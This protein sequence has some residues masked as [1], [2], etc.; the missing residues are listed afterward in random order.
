MLII[1]SDDDDVTQ[2]CFCLLLCVVM[3]V[4]FLHVAIGK[5]VTI[6]TSI[7]KFVIAL[8]QFAQE[9]GQKCQCKLDEDAA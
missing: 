2:Q 8:F 5:A 9:C 7:T 6:T 4:T 3:T 1:Y